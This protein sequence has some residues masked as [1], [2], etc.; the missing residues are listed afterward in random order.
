[1]WR[2]GNSIATSRHAQTPVP[3]VRPYHRDIYNRRTTTEP[4]KKPQKFFSDRNWNRLNSFVFKLFLDG[5][6]IR[7]YVINKKQKKNGEILPHYYTQ[8]TDTHTYVYK[9]PNVTDVIFFL[10]KGSGERLIIYE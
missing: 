8:Q 6:G 3:F 1:V 7:D 2:K 10:E 5:Q 4:K 9:F